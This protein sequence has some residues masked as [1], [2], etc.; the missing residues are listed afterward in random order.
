MIVEVEIGAGT[1]AVVDDVG[2]RVASRRL[3]REAGW[4]TVTGG[5]LARMRS[6]EFEAMEPAATEVLP[7]L[8][9][10]AAAGRTLTERRQLLPVGEVALAVGA[11][12]PT[13]PSPLRRSPPVRRHEAAGAGFF[14][15]P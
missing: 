10:F 7:G 9:R 12:G 13:T 3:R 14:G 2:L 5:G 1:H 11:A 6:I 4:H 8:G 15:G